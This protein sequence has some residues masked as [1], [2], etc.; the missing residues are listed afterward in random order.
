VRFLKN[1]SIY[2]GIDVL[3]AAI[4]IIS[5]PITTRL[6]TQKQ[7]GTIPLISA[8][9]AIMMILRFGGMDWSYLFFR[10]RKGIDQYA[11]LVT[12]TVSA[13]FF[14]ILTVAGFAGVALW[15]P[16]IKNFVDITP[17]ELWLYLA[18]LLPAAFVDW[19]LYTL[20]FLHQAAAFARI[21][22]LQRIISVVIVLP[23][24]F[25]VPQSHRLAFLIGTTSAVSVLALIWALFELH[26]I[27]QWPYRKSAFDRP[28]MTGM[29]NYGLYMIPGGIAY[30]FV[31][32][33]DRLLV[34]GLKGTTEV[35]ILALG[36]SLGVVV[37]KMKKWIELTFNPHMAE[38]LAEDEARVYL[39][40]LN[41]TILMLAIIFFPLTALITV[42]SGPVVSLL[43]PPAYVRVG[44]LVPVIALSG[45]FSVL[46]MVAIATLLI[47]PSKTL[48]FLIN[49]SA[50]AINVI[51]GL[52]LIS[53]LGALGAAL[54]TVAAEG[55]ILLSWIGCG[56]KLYRN[57]A[58]NWR[59][60]LW[61]STLTIAL[62]I[63]CHL[64]LTPSGMLIPRVGITAALAA[65]LALCLKF[66]APLWQL[67]NEI[68]SYLKI[69]TT[70]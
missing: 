50:L 7:Y 62:M 43:Y 68:L 34:G 15:T 2:A 58:L 36:T 19:Y 26:K 48:P 65:V 64:V 32:V 11:V 27:G 66:Y 13:S 45:T 12:A 38:W 22:I 33:T 31:A 59:P 53:T 5:S 41:R 56:S 4:G 28:M 55:L 6:L 67:K 39:A 40:K 47:S 17:L 3:G 54:G 61:G 30:A 52:A 35:A 9:W 25:I 14:S 57:L 69:D 24:L 29:L 23:L 70:K 20:R 44:Q 18:G 63:A 60:A 49:C 10:V 46:T 16:W 37:V 1:L 21:A 42:W 8:L 51:I